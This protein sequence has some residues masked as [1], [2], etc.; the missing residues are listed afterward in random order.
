MSDSFIE[1]AVGPVPKPPIGLLPQKIHNKK[2]ALEI[3]GAMERYVRAD[4]LIPD[5]WLYE[6]KNLYG[7]T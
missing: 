1:Q 4:K 7:T 3:I 2:R 5:E 6:L